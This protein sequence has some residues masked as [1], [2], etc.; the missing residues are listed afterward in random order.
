[1]GVSRDRSPR[2]KTMNAERRAI[3]ERAVDWRVVAAATL[4]ILAASRTATAENP[5]A[6]PEL[7]ESGRRAASAFQRADADGNG[8]LTLAEFLASRPEANRQHERRR[9]IVFDF[10][11]SETLGSEEFRQL[12]AP[13]DERGK[14]PDPIV[15]A[16]QA[17]FAKWE[18]IFKSADKGGEGRLTR[19]AWPAKA[20]SSEIPAVADVPFELWDHDHNGAVDEAEGRWLL[21]VAYGLTQLDGRPMRAPQGRVFAWF[22]FRRLDKNSNGVLSREEFVSGHDQGPEKNAELFAQ[23]DT[24]RDGKLTAEETWRI[25]WHDNVAWFFTF[26]RNQ[27]GYVTTDEFIATGWATSLGRRMVR[28]FDGDGD[29]KISFA[30]FRG[31]P[32]ANLSS[33]WDWPRRDANNDGRLS[34]NEFY[35]EKSPQLI[36]QGRWFFD[37]FDRDK[38][39]FLSYAELEFDGS[40]DKVPPEVLFAAR[41]LDGDGKVPFAEFF[42]EAKPS[43]SDARALDGYEMRLAAAENQFLSA[44]KDSSDYL[45][46]EEFVD[47]QRAAIEASRRQAKVLSDRKT[48]LEGNY[49]VRKSVL[50]VNEIAFLAVVWVVMRRT[51]PTKAEPA[52]PPAQ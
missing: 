32:F 49:W 4:W 29:R 16:E 39:G 5:P 41:D 24:D 6:S 44:D 42:G 10:D 52:A 13:L 19:S 8:Q 9:F 31:T 48:L 40:L 15:Q 46:R 27:D 18:D 3:T 38:D 2:L 1:M 23:L 35:L 14:I 30:E 26:D 37:H 20:L 33:N 47:S 22:G 45:D 51:R 12:L 25:L 21:E 7:L 43:Q 11:G 28:A 17:A 36:A 34:W 50:I